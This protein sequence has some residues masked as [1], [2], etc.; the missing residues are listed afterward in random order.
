MVSI[1]GSSID[2]VNF[3]NFK[4]GKVYGTKF[5][6]VNGDAV[7]QPQLEPGIKD[8]TMCLAPKQLP[9]NLQY[10]HLSATMNISFDESQQ[11]MT[12]SL[13]GTGSIRRGKFDLMTS[14]V[15][16]ELLALDL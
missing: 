7:R 6:D 4:A 2:S 10:S 11:Q 3:G 9:P 15:H 13:Q 14:S 1:S 16:L 8:W 5:N 12:I